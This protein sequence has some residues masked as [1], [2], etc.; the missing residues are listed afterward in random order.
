M[1]EQ[2]PSEQGTEDGEEVWGKTAQTG[3]WE[4]SS[5]ILNQKHKSFVPSRKKY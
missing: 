5:L 3:P 1:Q 2:S 4:R